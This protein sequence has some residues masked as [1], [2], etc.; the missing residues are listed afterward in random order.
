MRNLLSVVT[1]TC[2]LLG[3]LQWVIPIDTPMGQR[4]VVSVII[5][6]SIAYAAWIV[7]QSKCRPWKTPENFVTV[8]V[9][10]KWRR[11]VKSPIIMGPV[12]LFGGVSLTF[13]PLYLFWCGQA[14]NFGVFEW[15][16]VPL[17]FLVVYIVPG[18]YMSLAS[19]VMAEL[20]KSEAQSDHAGAAV[21]GTP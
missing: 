5:A 19:E 3:I 17:C 16:V 20:F 1:A 15:I 7:Y 21:A 4:I 2:V 8:K 10:A 11:R 14:D 6:A 9:D 12:A 13:A 18:F